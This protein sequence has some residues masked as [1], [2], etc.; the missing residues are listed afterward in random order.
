[1]RNLVIDI[2]NSNSKFGLFENDALLEVQYNLALNK[3]D[4][5]AW[6]QHAQ[7]KNAIISDVRQAGAAWMDLLSPL[8]NLTVFNTQIGAGIH[9]EYETQDTLGP[10]RWAKMIGVSHINKAGNSLVIDAGTCITIDLLEG[11]VSYKGGVI[12][13]G[14][15]MRFDALHHYTGKLPLV[16]WDPEFNLESGKNTHD[17]IRAGVIRGVVYEVE[18]HLNIYIKKYK[19][20]RIYFSG[21]NAGLLWAQ[22]K[23][24]IFAPQMVLEPFLV[25]K[26]LNEVIKLK[27]CN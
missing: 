23:N 11:G 4:M 16:H 8:V 25:L 27:T 15:Q 14:V 13:P 12:S 6:I 20:L 1:M 26:G 22:L 10:D 19:D 3:E 2:G 17:A 18:G 24:S 21:G 5:R 7:I 9:S